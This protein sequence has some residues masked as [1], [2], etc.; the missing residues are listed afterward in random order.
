MLDSPPV[1]VGFVTQL[2]FERYG[3]FWRDV[4]AGAGATVVLPTR[5]GVQAHAEVVDPELA[6]GPWFRLTAAHAASLAACD[7]LIV[8]ELNPEE[9]E[10]R[11]SAQDRWVADLA[12]A[13]EDAVAGLPP[14]VSVAAYPDPGIESRAVGLLQSLLRDAA[15]VKRVWARHRAEAGKLSRSTSARTAHSVVEK[16]ALPTQALVG[17]PWAVT[18]AVMRAATAAGLTGLSQ[19][20]LDAQRAREEGWSYDARLIPT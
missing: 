10:V 18:D 14:L 19:R 3:T 16:S 12:G 2:L 11:G 13:L 8:P 6:P 9:D 4:V 5:E 17:Q 15:A 7:L 20:A 1:R